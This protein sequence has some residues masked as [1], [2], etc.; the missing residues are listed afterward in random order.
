MLQAAGTFQDPI[1]I[2]EVPYTTAAESLSQ[3]HLLLSQ[4]AAS[5]CG[6]SATQFAEQKKLVFAYNEQGSGGPT[7]F[8][9]CNSGDFVQNFWLMSC[10]RKLSG[11]SGA[12]AGTAGCTCKLADEGRPACPLGRYGFQGTVTTTP[13][14]W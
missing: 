2:P 9:L 14:Y 6:Y 13:D 8:N 7:T 4:A 1:V 10:P 11:A 12:D 5:L 3:G